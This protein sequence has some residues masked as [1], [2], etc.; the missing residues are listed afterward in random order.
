MNRTTRILAAPILVAMLAACPAWAQSDKQFLSDAL[1]GSNGEIAL[2]NL[3]QKK[4]SAEPVRKFASELAADHSKA[5]DEI[6]ILATNLHVKVTGQLAPEI[7][8]AIVKL[9]DLSG[10]AF[11]QEF[12]RV[13]IDD[14]QKDIAQF[15]DKSEQK[16]G[17]TAELA[18]RML[19]VLEKH[20]KTAQSLSAK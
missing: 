17:E 11:D 5:K 2:A 16:N 15:K 10:P 14:H 4:G 13:L 1:K 20:L 18:A 19:P 6:S 12:I 9:Q 3:A 8:Q 7:Q